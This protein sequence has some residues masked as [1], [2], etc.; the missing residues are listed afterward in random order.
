MASYE[1][2]YWYIDENFKPCLF[3]CRDIKEDMYKKGV[4]A[5]VFNL[6]STEKFSIADMQT[7]A[8]KLQDINKQ[9]LISRD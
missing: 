9:F 2:T 8:E 1:K 4:L 3:R 5:R 6:F 7:Q